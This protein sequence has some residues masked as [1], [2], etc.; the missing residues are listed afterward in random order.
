MYIKRRIVNATLKKK[1]SFFYKREIFTETEI[2]KCI[3]NKKQTENSNRHPKKHSGEK[4]NRLLK[5]EHP[6][7]VHNAGL[8]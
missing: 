1:L 8:G 3:I 2:G 7:I 6:G 5:G 4:T